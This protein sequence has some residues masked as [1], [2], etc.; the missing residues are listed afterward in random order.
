MLIVAGNT[1]AFYRGS[2]K[3]IPFSVDLSDSC[4]SFR[5]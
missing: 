3:L 4:S 5:V 1:L 2:G